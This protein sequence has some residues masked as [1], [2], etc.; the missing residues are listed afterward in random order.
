MRFLVPGI[1]DVAG[2]RTTW[3]ADPWDNVFILVEKVRRTDRPYYRQF[4]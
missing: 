1:A 3:F 2:L 4:G